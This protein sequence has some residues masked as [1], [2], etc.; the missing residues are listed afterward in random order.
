MGIFKND[1]GRPS[2]K[3]IIVRNILKGMAF[4]VVCVALIAGGY[5]LNDC[6]NKENYN[7]VSDKEIIENN[8]TDNE[9]DN[10]MSLII[11]L[12]SK[13]SGTYYFSEKKSDD[14]YN[15]IN[16]P[17][18]KDNK[19]F[20]KDLSFD[21]KMSMIVDKKS[22]ELDSFDEI[23]YED[24]SKYYYDI[25]GEEP[26]KREFYSY[27]PASIGEV[28]YSNGVYKFNGKEVTM[29]LEDSHPKFEL[30]KFE[31]VGDDNIYLY[32]IM[33]YDNAMESSA[34]NYDTVKY[35]NENKK[36]VFEFPTVSESYESSVFE[37]RRNFSKNADK[38]TQ[39]K[40]TLTKNDKDNYVFTSVEKV[41]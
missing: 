36:V 11:E 9:Y 40:W 27:S 13:V 33:Y 30:V 16:S 32:E 8:S 38:F 24:F 7:C 26:E 28:K 1:V 41:K 21:F 29:V 5:F 23:S 22:L 39:F 25:F 14:I 34:L 12:Y 3:T 35:Y 4:V 15:F 2:N 17:I 18:Y 20:S 10:V 31:I 19:V 37:L 6:K